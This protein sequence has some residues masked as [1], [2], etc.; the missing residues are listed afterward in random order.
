MDNTNNKTQDKLTL[1]VVAGLIVVLAALVIGLSLERQAQGPA[2]ATQA[3]TNSSQLA[4]PY[5]MPTGACLDNPK[6]C[7][8][9][10]FGN[11]MICFDRHPN[12]YNFCAALAKA[13]VN[14]CLNAP[15][16]YCAQELP[17]SSL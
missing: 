11:I 4:S 13:C 1:F 17:P 16:P 14:L 6:D 10:C 8:N 15:E 7:L 2:V 9:M 5:I 3:I 12:N